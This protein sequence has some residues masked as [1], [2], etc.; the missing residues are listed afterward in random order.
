MMR[1]DITTGTAIPL[2]LFNPFDSS[3]Q[4]F[5]NIMGQGHVEAPPVVLTSAD[6]EQSDLSNRV[7]DINIKVSRK[8]RRN[9]NM[10]F[11]WICSTDAAPP[12]TD[13][14]FHGIASF[15]TLLKF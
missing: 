1:I 6:V 8:F 3:D 12:G 9:S 10:P 7:V 11:F 4:E 15:R 14:T 13:N 2:Q 5:Q